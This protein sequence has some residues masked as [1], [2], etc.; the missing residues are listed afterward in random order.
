MSS[1]LVYIAFSLDFPNAAHIFDYSFLEMIVLDLE[2][3][4]FSKDLSKTWFVLC[5][6]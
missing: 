3:T 2:L 6:A 1:Y 4:W 5:D